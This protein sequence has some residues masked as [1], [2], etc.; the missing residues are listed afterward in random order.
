MLYWVRSKIKKL[1]CKHSNL[2]YKIESAA[3]T[4]EQV[5]LRCRDCDKV[6]EN[7]GLEC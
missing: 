1:F 3:C 2:Y 6:L 4:C 7:K 5:E